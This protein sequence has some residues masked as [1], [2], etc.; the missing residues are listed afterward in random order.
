[1]CHQV[2]ITKPVKSLAV[3]QLIALSVGVRGLEA[4]ERENPEYVGLTTLKLYDTMVDALD[5]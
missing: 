4:L 5:R 3:E 2:G 1:V